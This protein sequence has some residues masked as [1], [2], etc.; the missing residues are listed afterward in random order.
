MA[1]DPEVGKRLFSTCG[2]LEQVVLNNRR[3]K[4]KKLV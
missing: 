4:K 2:R 1:K 3:Y